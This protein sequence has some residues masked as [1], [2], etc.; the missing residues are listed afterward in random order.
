MLEDIYRLEKLR[1]EPLT[2]KLEDD[3]FCLLPRTAGS[4]NQPG[5][6]SSDNIFLRL[7]THNAQ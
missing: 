3:L 4:N 6:I 1:N 5:D 2:L 7:I